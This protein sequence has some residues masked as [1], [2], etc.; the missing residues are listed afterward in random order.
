[1]QASSAEFDTLVKGL[2]ANITQLK[3]NTPNETV[4]ELQ[5]LVRFWKL[6]IHK[7]SA[8]GLGVALLISYD[9]LRPQATQLPLDFIAVKYKS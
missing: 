5:V 8:T 7:E 1:M 9:V 2:Q 3:E 6:L 4:S